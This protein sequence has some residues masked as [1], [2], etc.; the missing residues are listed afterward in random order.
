MH[1]STNTVR[2]HAL[3]YQS[4]RL[5]LHALQYQQVCMHFRTNK[6]ACTAVPISQ[7]RIACT[8]VSTSLHCSTN[9]AT[10]TAVLIRLH[11]LQYQQRCLHYVQISQI[12]LAWTAVSTDRRGMHCCTCCAALALWISLFYEIHIHIYIH[13]SFVYEYCTFRMKALNTMTAYHW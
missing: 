12:S 13:R 11:A 7:A 5:G 10:C 9:K 1:C 4:A 8:A 6:A 3:Q 2:L